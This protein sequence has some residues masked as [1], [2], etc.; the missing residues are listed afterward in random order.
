MVHINNGILLRHKKELNNA[1]CSNMNGTRGSHTKWN[2]SERERQIPYDITYTCNLIYGINE[3]FHRKETHGHGE[4]ICGCQWGGGGSGMDGSLGLID[5]NYCF[6]SG[7]AMRACC[8]AE[9]TLSN[10][11]WWNMMEDNVR[12]KMYIYVWLGRFAV[13]QKLTEHCKPIIMLKIK[14]I[15]K[16][17]IPTM[18]RWRIQENWNGLILSMVF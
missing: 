2:K 13:Q 17:T 9:G 15:K 12:R 16:M 5:A 7:W 14:I 8:I 18:Y 3:S 10:H 1:I 11:L 4:Q 6:W